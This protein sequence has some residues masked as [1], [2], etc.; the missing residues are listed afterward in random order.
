MAKGK[1]CIE[2][3]KSNGLKQNT[4]DETKEQIIDTKVQLIA[5]KVKRLVPLS[6]LYAILFASYLLVSI[7]NML[8]VTGK[9]SELVFIQQTNTQFSLILMIVFS[10]LLL[11]IHHFMK[12][13]WLIYHLMNAIVVVFSVLLI[14]D[15]ART[16]YITLGVVFLTAL[17]VFFTQRSVMKDEHESD[18]TPFFALLL[19]ILG[20]LVMA[21]V[22]SIATVNRYNTFN[23]STFDFGIFAQMYEYMRDTGF[24]TTTLE[25]NMSLSH[26]AI[27]FSPIY[28]LLLP[29]YFIFSSPEYLLIMQAIVICLGVF[30]VYLLCRHFKI[31]NINSV[32]ISGSYLLYPAIITP[33]FFDFHENKFLTVLLLWLFYFY[34]RKKVIPMYLSL[35]LVLLVKEDAA[36]YIIF[37][38]LFCM[39]AK[40]DYK[41][42]L[43]IMISGLCYFGVVITGMELFGHGIMDN[44]FDIYQLPGQKGL[45]VVAKNIL[46]NPMF[47][48]A[49][50][51]TEEKLR[52]IIYLFVPLAFVPFITKKWQSYTLMIPIIVMNLMTAYPYQFDIGYQ[53]TYGVSAILFYLFIRNIK[54]FTHKWK[55]IISI[56]TL[57]ASLLFLLTST[58]EFFTSYNQMFTDYKIERLETEEAL[59]MIPQDASVTSQTYFTAHLS[60][61]KELYDYP[62]PEWTDFVVLD[63]RDTE[64]AIALKIKQLEDNG[65]VLY[66]SGGL[67]KVYK[68]K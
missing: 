6:P 56:I 18:C 66:V 4:V 11:V 15:S 13:P 1:K 7:F 29:G 31:G 12:K 62:Y 5:R 17:I 20:F 16:V 21:T 9:S 55:R 33:A 52:Y 49:N 43:W 2:K 50:L 3:V 25:R 42:G 68:K 23:A 27:H 32:F 37:F 65:Y 48:V 24:P 47:F 46:A 22:L 67:A 28:Y 58:Q 26:F 53:Y 8:R 30:P 51:F 64:E 57:I 59:S 35:I 61:V 45:G 54:E 38:G 39:L 60:R 44:R 14:R 19:I 34:E 41:H 63:V 36:L 10:G 40:K